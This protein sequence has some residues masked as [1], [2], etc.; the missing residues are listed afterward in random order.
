MVQLY[1]THIPTS[2]LQKGLLTFGSAVVSILN[3]LRA[4]MVAAVGETTALRPVLKK[5]HRR[6]ENDICGRKIL[7]DRPR[8]TSATVDLT[9]LRTLPHGTLGKEY[10]LFLERLNTTPDERPAVKFIDDGDDLL[11][12]MQRYRET[13]DFNHVI[14]QMKTTM[15]E[16]VTVKYFE[17]MQLGLPMCVLGGALSGLRLG[18]KHRRAFVLHY[19]PWCME[20]AVNSQLLIAV[21]W[22]NHFEVPI[23]ELQKAC[24]IT[25]FRKSSFST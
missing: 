22:E 2:L 18:P 19:L 10:S 8:I 12:I 7:R 11:Y 5:I 16:E 4:D 3:P 20:Q 25:P 15:L 9:F 24:S 23:S 17:G 1:P 14:L 13:H 21:D 6:M